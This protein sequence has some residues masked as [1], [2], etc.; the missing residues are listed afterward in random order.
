MNIKV[1][2]LEGVDHLFRQSLTEASLD[3]F[4]HQLLDGRGFIELDQERQG[5]EEGR[6][7]TILLHQVLQPRKGAVGF[8]LDLQPSFF[9]LDNPLSV[10]RGIE[11]LDHLFDFG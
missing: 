10:D 7:R 11:T 5:L 6:D 9:L 8:N 1:N 2:E 3:Y 4:F